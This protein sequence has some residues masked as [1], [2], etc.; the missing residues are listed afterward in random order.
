MSMVA[1]RLYSL[2][3]HFKMVKLNDISNPSLLRIP[4]QNRLLSEGII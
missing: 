4:F 1:I 3:L 2:T